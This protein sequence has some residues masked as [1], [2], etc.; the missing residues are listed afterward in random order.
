MTAYF[1]NMTWCVAV[2]YNSNNFTKDQNKG[3]KFFRRQK[4]DNLKNGFKISRAKIYQ[5]LQR[6][7]NSI[8]KDTVTKQT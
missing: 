1:V 5:K 3:L 6:F 7:V 4:G 2:G 8:L